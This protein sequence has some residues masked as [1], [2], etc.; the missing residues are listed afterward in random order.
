MRRVLAAA[1]LATVAAFVSAGTLS[2]AA[3]DVETLMGKAMAELSKDNSSG[4][5]SAA[6]RYLEAVLEAQP[7]HLEAQWQLLILRMAPSRNVPL[8]ERPR[9]LAAF[10]EN[11][12]HI[13][14]LA[15]DS[16]S[17]AFLHYTTAWHASFY[18][19][20]DRALS[21]IDKAL[22]LG[23]RSARYQKAKGTLLIEAGQ[24]EDDDGEVERGI[25]ILQRAREQARTSPSMFVHDV[26]FDFDVAQAIAGMQ[27]PRWPE[28]I[29]HYERY[30]QEAPPGTKTY[31]FALNNVSVAYRRAGDCARARESAEKALTVMKF[32]AAEMNKRYSDFCLEMQKPAPA[33]AH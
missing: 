19:D 9:I 16:R 25:A 6:E 27:Q 8:S 22:A 30:I 17:E 29:E 23:P 18:D 21:E 15:K 24:L 4:D 3:D 11:Y 7:N 13:A 10:S 20:Y 28:V 32:G 1:C 31:A 14:K 2:L 12:S 33:A 5:T 26:Q